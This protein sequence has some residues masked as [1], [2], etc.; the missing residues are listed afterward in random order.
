MLGKKSIIL[1]LIYLKISLPQTYSEQRLK[2]E[3]HELSL[4]AQVRVIK[5]KI[6]LYKKVL[7][8][9]E[10]I[11]LELL[12]THGSQLEA[13]KHTLIVMIK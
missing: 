6:L 3:N 8:P 4:S 10:C 13:E 2:L 11:P 12:I 7:K 5:C 1:C 9:R